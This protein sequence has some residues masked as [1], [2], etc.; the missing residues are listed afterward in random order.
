M[1]TT[2]KR[3]IVSVGALAVLAVIFVASCGLTGCR[4][5]GENRS[6]SSA[7]ANTGTTEIPGLPPDPG[8]AGKATLAGIDSDNDGVRD[9]IQRYI[10]LTY[11][12]STKNQ[13][14]LTQMAKVMQNALLD[15]NDKQ[16]SV[17]HGEEVSKASE[18]HTYLLG[19]DV[20]AVDASY[21]MEK[22]MDSIIL[23][24]DA[25]NKAY[26]TYN[27]QLGG[28][29]FFGTPDSQIATACDFDVASLPN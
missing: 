26:F 15:A 14:A 24:T 27:D 6:N 18:C 2:K 21:K 7:P 20:A 5:N 1:N 9:D 13:A 4:S 28:E 29:V 22:D 19:N 25:R 17:K 12:N 23:N 10:A 3:L 11:P 16:K 8:E